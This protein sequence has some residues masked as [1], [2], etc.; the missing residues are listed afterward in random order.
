MS[1]FGAFDPVGNRGGLTQGE[2]NLQNTR[3][4]I[5]QEKQF[6]SVH[7]QYQARI[8]ELEAKLKQANFDKEILRIRLEVKTAEEVATSAQSDKLKA[9]V[10]SNFPNHDLFKKTGKHCK[11]GAQ[12][13]FF[14][15]IWIGEFDKYLVGKVPGN[16]IDYRSF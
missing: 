7:E 9:I 3:A 13:T 16:P 12:E 10:K 15:A 5:A 6:N 1:I 14:G 2:I 11:D 8:R 4:R